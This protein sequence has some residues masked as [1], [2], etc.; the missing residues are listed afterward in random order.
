MCPPDHI[1]ADQTTGYV[2][3]EMGEIVDSR[4]ICLEEARSEKPDNIGVV[5][6]YDAPF[7]SAYNM[8]K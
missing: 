8:M 3:K 2:S 6:R 5:E 1:S 4:K 7:R